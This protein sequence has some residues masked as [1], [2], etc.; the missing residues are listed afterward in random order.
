MEQDED[1]THRRVNEAFDLLDE[2][3]CR[4]GGLIAEKRGD[5]LLAEFAQ[6]S[7]ALGAALAFQGDADE[8][9]AVVEDDIRP[10]MRIGI[11]L[12]EVIADRGTLWGPGVNLAQRV[13][14]LAPPGGVAVSDT[15]FNAVSKSIPVDYTDL[16][17]Q[18]VKE[19]MIQPCRMI[20]SRSSSQTASWKTSLQRCQSCPD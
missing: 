15:V 4:Y 11:N 19:A 8:L 17:Q 7:D 9:F 18:Q 5:A 12:G 1:L 2:A 6:P 10:Q 13:E 16:G 20:R 3:V 14:Q